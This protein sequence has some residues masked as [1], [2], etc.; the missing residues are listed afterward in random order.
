[1]PID[2]QFIAAAKLT[3]DGMRG[4]NLKIIALNCDHAFHS[5]EVIASGANGRVMHGS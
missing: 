5:V 2:E 1:L 3:F 4:G